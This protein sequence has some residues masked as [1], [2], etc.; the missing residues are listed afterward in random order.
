MTK[1]PM[2]AEELMSEVTRVV[3]RYIDS[4]PSSSGDN[5]P[6]YV[7]RILSSKGKQQRVVVYKMLNHNR[8]VGRNF[9]TLKE[10]ARSAGCS[11]SQVNNIRR[12]WRSDVE[13]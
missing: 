10:M 4:Q 9:F 7:K 5:G 2:T 3:Q 13:L 1:I 8:D 12:E 6:T 11:L